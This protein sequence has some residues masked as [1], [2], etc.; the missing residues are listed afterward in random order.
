LNKKQKVTPVEW[1][2][3]EAIW[4]LG[5]SPS[6]REVIES[7]FSA[8]QKAYTTIQT[9][10]NTLVAKGALSRKKIGLVNFYK[11]TKNRRSLVKTEVGIMINRVFKGSASSLANYLIDS[12]KLTLDE[13]DDI[14]NLL[15]A[16]EKQL[17]EL[18]ND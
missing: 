11:P 14:K 4:N 1:E 18:E 10:M 16:K 12:E 5:G 6:V 13:I 9:I 7:N 3:M 8:S 15:A 2:I 17:K